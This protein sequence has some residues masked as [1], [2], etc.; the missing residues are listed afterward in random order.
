MHEITI[1]KEHDAGTF[2]DIMQKSKYLLLKII[3]DSKNDDVTTAAMI[4]CEDAK[5]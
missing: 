5:N 4:T 2:I 3:Q 1:E